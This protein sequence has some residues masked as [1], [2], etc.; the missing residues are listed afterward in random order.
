MR[1]KGRGTD[2][3]NLKKNLLFIF[4]DQHRKFDLGCYG[5]GEVLTPHL[6]EL[7]NDG[8]RFEHCC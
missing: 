8:E 5:N 1:G 2:M 3:K 7:S 4:S 6:D